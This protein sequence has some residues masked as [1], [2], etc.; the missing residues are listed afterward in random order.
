MTGA[1][2]MNSRANHRGVSS[3]APKQYEDFME[4]NWPEK[5][6]W[7]PELYDLRTLRFEVPRVAHGQ[8]SQSPAI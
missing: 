2:V 1:P 5:R 6:K 8:A 4:M 7:L 3:A